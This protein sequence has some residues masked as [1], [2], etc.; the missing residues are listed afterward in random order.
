MRVQVPDTDPQRAYDLIRDFARYPELSDVVEEVVVNPPGAD[1]SVISE[2]LVRFRKGM[3]KWTER[4]VFEPGRRVIRFVQLSGDFDVFE[5]Q[6]RVE[7]R[8]GGSEICLDASFDLGIPTLADLLDPV[9]EASFRANILRILSG[10]F[11][12]ALDVLTEVLSRPAGHGP[13]ASMGAK[14]RDIPVATQ[15]PGGNSL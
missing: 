8:A 12:S 13:A 15:H 2:W 1:G 14:G 4:D 7:E 9:A 6:W 10:I 5:G 3:L 11:G